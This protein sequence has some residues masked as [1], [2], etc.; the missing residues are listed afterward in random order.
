MASACMSSGSMA[1]AS[2]PWRNV[3]PPPYPHPRPY[4]RCYCEENAYLVVQHLAEFAHARNQP[5]E[6]IGARQTT[7]SSSSNP[8]I[9][10]ISLTRTSSINAPSSPEPA[11]AATSAAGGGAFQLVWDVRTIFISNR[12]KSVVL[13][14]QCASSAPPEEHSPVIWDYHVVAALT[15]TLVPVGVPIRDVKADRRS[16]LSR[17][18]H[19]RQ[20]DEP[21]PN[22]LFQSRTWVY[23]PDS[24]LSYTPA[25]LEDLKQAG[26]S[27]PVPQPV[28]LHDY[29]D[30][31]FKPAL[32]VQDLVQP[33]LRSCL[34]IVD[35][36]D[37]LA[38]F[39]SDRSHMLLPPIAATGQAE[40]WSSPPPPWPPL[41]G[42][43]A[44]AAK[45]TNNLME[46]YVAMSPPVSS[47]NAANDGDAAYGQ[48]LDDLS[49]FSGGW[50]S[51]ASPG[52]TVRCARI[53][54]PADPTPS[55]RSSWSRLSLRRGRDRAQSLPSS[56]G[57]LG[58]VPPPA[59][60]PDAPLPPLPASMVASASSSSSLC[61]ASS[62]ISSSSG[63]T[64]SP[65]LSVTSPD[66]SHDSSDAKA[67]TV[68]DDDARRTRPRCPPPR[69]SGSAQS[70]P[71]AP[72]SATPERER[73]GGRVSSPLFPAYLAASSQKRAE[74]PVSPLT[75]PPAP[76][77]SQSD[78]GMLAVPFSAMVRSV[79]LDGT[80]MAAQNRQV[81]F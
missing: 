66:I 4:T 73:R 80:T 55:T 28:P 31:T 6:R 11:T 64:T 54:K 51:T 8:S 67:S 35:A 20:Q 72:Q 23:D 33:H 57:R 5:I 78:R 45:V 44:K 12:R 27:L 59:P 50:T 53:G 3:Q 37:L 58:A 26:P 22:A 29:L 34:R 16:L 43:L 40:T 63:G 75:P 81:D 62:S 36:K 18:G 25:Q 38:H 41:V 7:T 30:G 47:N 79:S 70:F 76:S 77:R 24:R 61:A 46:R 14:Q 39:A 15:C 32:V 21:K 56:R 1:S 19:Q 42:H 2:S 13:W 60:P 17:K 49:F 9:A 48:V 69:P 10:R 68:V 65:S 74:T 52:E 71:G